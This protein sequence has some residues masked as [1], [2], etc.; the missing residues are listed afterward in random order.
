MGPADISTCCVT[1]LMSSI[2]N[3]M[4]KGENWLWEC[5]PWSQYACCGTYMTTL[6]HIHLAHMFTIIIIRKHVFKELPGR[7]IISKN[8]GKTC[9]NW[10]TILSHAQW[11]QLSSQIWIQSSST[12]AGDV[13]P[14]PTLGH[15]LLKCTVIVLNQKQTNNKTRG[16][17]MHWNFREIVCFLILMLQL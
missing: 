14:S 15:F 1:L 2:R 13:M 17:Q 11:L 3:P 10:S 16:A 4:V 6:S 5:V 8:A 7:Q 9:D 12:E